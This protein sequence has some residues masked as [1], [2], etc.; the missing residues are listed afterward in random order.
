MARKSSAVLTQ[1]AP[2]VPEGRTRCGHT[3]PTIGCRAC[4]AAQSRRRRPG[5][6]RGRGWT[7][8]A[9]RKKRR[10]RRKP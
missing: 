5:R 3:A 9:S 4:E 8:P 1:V 6:L 7:K 2:S 10:N